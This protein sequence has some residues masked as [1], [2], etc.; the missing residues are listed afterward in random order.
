MSD[1]ADLLDHGYVSLVESWGSDERIIESARVSTN[2][3][4]IGWGDDE[5]SGDE[6]LLKYLWSHGHMTPFEMCGFSVEVMA[7][8]FVVREWQRHRTQSYSELSA[9]YTPVPNVNYIPSIER[10]TMGF[11]NNNKQASSVPGSN[12]LTREE[13]VLFRHQLRYHYDQAEHVYRQ[14]L[15]AGVPKELA[16][17]HLPVGRYTRMRASANLR[18][19]LDFLR[20]RMAPDAQWEIRQYANAIGGFV[21]KIYPRTWELVNA[22]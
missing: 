19:W 8:I 10:L 22:S 5:K 16:R 12:P 9:R 11:D 4:F 20:Q 7:P 18:N 14:A 2:K 1:K 21:G 15:S 17:V 3:G 13:A 6:K